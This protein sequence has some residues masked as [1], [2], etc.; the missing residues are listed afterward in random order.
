MVS[1]VYIEASSNDLI[2]TGHDEKIVW[3]QAWLLLESSSHP[4]KK[5]HHL[6]HPA[7]GPL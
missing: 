3:D 4:L 5:T 7:G 6:T 2:R 1:S